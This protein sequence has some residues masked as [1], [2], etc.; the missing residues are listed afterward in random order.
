MAGRERAG[1]WIMWTPAE[2]PGQN[3]PAE[4]DADAFPAK[5]R[6][7]VATGVHTPDSVAQTVATAAAE[8]VASSEADGLERSTIRQYRQHVELHILPFVGAVK[9]SKLTAAV[10]DFRDALARAGRSPALIRKV[11]C[12]RR[13][14]SRALLRHQL[15]WGN[16]P[17]SPAPCRR[18]APRRSFPGWAGHSKRPRNKGY[19]RRR[20]CPGRRHCSPSPCSA[21]CAHRSLGVWSR[22]MMAQIRMPSIGMDYG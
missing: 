4:K 19:P 12:H 6:V 13:Q 5:A 11:I 16:E 2:T 1:L 14:R 18:E 7:E 22:S 8:W 9:L 10:H 20:P 3:L 15:C 21:D 17:P